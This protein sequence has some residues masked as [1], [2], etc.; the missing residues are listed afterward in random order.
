MLTEVSATAA[1]GQQLTF[2]QRSI[3]RGLIKSEWVI[4]VLEIEDG[5]AFNRPASG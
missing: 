2:A 4:L 5:Q 1:T 3:W